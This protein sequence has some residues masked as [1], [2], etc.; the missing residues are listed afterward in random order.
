MLAFCNGGCPKD[1]F[2]TTDNGETGL[3]VLCS[4][5]RSFFRHAAPELERLS[6]HMKGGRR[7][8]FRPAG[9]GA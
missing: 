9:P 6:A 7:A 1:R 8:G 5:Y 2:L 4:A 3:N